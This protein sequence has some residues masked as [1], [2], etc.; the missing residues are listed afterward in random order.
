MVHIHQ[1]H[2]LGLDYGANPA[3][4]SHYHLDLGE[5]CVKWILF[6]LNFVISLVG[7]C[8]SGLGIYVATAAKSYEE[9]FGSGSVSLSYVFIGC[10]ILICLIGFLGCCGAMRHST[11]MLL[12]V[13]SQIKEAAVTKLAEYGNPVKSDVATKPIDV[14]QKGLDC[15]GIE[16]GPVEWA[17]DQKKA[18]YWIR[19]HDNDVPDSCCVTETTNCGKNEAKATPDP[20]VVHTKGCETALYD[21]LTD[22]MLLIGGL[23]VA[24][25]FLE[26]S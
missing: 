26:V 10:G 4:I 21:Y 9:F 13:K 17:A 20:A 2:H 22:N 16:T 1:A 11:F 18:T 25:A 15:C 12:M 24:V 7:L 3:R 19:T 23:G 8:V 6:A 5:S 14:V